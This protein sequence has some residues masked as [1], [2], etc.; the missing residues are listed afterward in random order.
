MEQKTGEGKQKIFKMGG[1]LIHGVGALKRGGGAGTPL[2]IMNQKRTLK[3]HGKV[4]RFDFVVS[5]IELK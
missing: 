1:K 5:E 4:L 2:Q 3:K